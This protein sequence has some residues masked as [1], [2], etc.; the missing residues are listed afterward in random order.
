MVAQKEVREAHVAF[1]VHH[2]GMVVVD[3]I[4][5]FRRW[6]KVAIT[7]IKVAKSWLVDIV[8][9]AVVAR[10]AFFEF[11]GT[12]HLNDV[13]LVVIAPQAVDGVAVH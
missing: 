9:N 5:E 6:P 10:L 8:V 1:A 12:L 2:G 13:H 11:V 4:G 7:H 3:A